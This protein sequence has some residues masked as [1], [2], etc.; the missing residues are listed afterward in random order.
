M[1]T[2]QMHLI[3]FYQNLEDGCKTPESQTSLTKWEHDLLEGISTSPKCQQGSKSPVQAPMIVP[4][5]TAQS[6]SEES[7]AS[8]ASLPSVG[9]SHLY[10]QAAADP[11]SRVVM[12]CPVATQTVVGDNI[13]TRLSIRE[14]YERMRKN[15]ASTKSQIDPVP[16]KHSLEKSLSNSPK[17]DVN[18][19]LGPVTIKKRKKD[20]KE[21]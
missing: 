13:D 3:S 5:L 14:Q 20:D 21:R 16:D 4:A 1:Y 15:E 8:A 7:T 19:V 12:I 10:W 2:T 9:V 6:V 18:S 17:S 11:V